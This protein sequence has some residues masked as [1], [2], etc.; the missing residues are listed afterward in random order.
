MG[1][2]VLGFEPSKSE[3]LDDGEYYQD[4]TIKKNDSEL[5]ITYTFNA[6]KQF[7]NGSVSFNGQT[8]KGKELTIVDITTLIAVM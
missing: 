1:L 4:F 7:I 5:C 3:A 2:K 8:L 6:D